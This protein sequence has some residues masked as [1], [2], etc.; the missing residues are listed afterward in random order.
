M[1]K[2][3]TIAMLHHIAETISGFDGVIKGL[4]LINDYITDIKSKE[5]INA[6]NPSKD[7]VIRR[8]YMYLRFRITGRESA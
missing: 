1:T 4:L 5:Q 2:E 3:E 6:T 7:N 8:H